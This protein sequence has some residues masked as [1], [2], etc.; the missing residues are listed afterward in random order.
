MFDKDT[1]KSELIWTGYEREI[2]KK[3]L[4]GAFAVIVS[5]CVILL[6]IQ[7][8]EKSEIVEKLNRADDIFQSSF[9][10]LCSNLNEQETA[11]TNEENRKLAYH[12]FSILQL[13]SFSESE[14]MNK[15]VHSLYDLSE[16]KELYSEIKETEKKDLNKLCQNLHDEKLLNKIIEEIY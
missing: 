13:T 8:K 16:K 9:S 2:M 12:C 1:D 5:V 10:L 7:T 4:T 15:V 6:V 14:A 11:E 3:V